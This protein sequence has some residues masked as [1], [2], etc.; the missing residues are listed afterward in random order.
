MVAE[1]GPD[2]FHPRANVRGV[3]EAAARNVHLIHVERPAV[4]ER[5]ERLAPALPFPSRDRDWRTV[6]EPDV[7]VNVVLSE[8]LLEPLG[9]EV[10]ERVRPTQRR[11]R[12][13]NAPGVNQKRVRAA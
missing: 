11:P 12:V 5:A 1:P 4:D 2:F 3:G 7:A 8:R 6:A 10:R 9:R 13:V